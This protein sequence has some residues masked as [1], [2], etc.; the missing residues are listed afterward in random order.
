M[1]RNPSLVRLIVY[2]PDVA[3]FKK[4]TYTAK[5][6]VKN[7]V[8]SPFAYTAKGELTLKGVTKAVD[9]QFNYQGTSEQE[10]EGKKMS[11]IGF[12]GQT[13]INRNDFKVGDTGLGDDVK[14]EVT[15]EAGQEKK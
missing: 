5:E 10:W 11:I 8:G 6:I 3:K 9:L 14:I 1:G 12:E 2:F 4:A 15:L 7:E 13:V